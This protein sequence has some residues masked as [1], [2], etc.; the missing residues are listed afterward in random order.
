MNNAILTAFLFIAM[1]SRRAMLRA[2]P[3]CSHDIATMA[4]IQI[5]QVHKSFGATAVLK[6]I[7]LDAHDGE[8]I[9]LVGPSGCGKSTLL[10]ILAVLGRQDTCEVRTGGANI[11]ALA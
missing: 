1:T 4:E 7:T 10:R 2:V 11:D 9:S 6:G 8:F 5:R 3:S